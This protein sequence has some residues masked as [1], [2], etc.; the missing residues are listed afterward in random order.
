MVV[1]YQLLLINIDIT[2]T[3]SDSKVENIHT[4]R[5]LDST[6]IKGLFSIVKFTALTAEDIIL[7][8]ILIVIKNNESLFITYDLKIAIV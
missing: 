8:N 5:V 7:E 2:L 4:D 3:I 1:S 6:S